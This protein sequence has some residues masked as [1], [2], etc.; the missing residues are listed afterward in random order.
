MTSGAF[1]LLFLSLNPNTYYERA[2]GIVLKLAK[3]FKQDSQDHSKV[4]VILKD[5]LKQCLGVV[6]L[7]GYKYAVCFP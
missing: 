2:P 6:P 4:N 1:F 3:A 5:F 7:C